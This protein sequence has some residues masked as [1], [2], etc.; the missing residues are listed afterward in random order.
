MF[1]I[2]LKFDRKKNKQEQCQFPSNKAN[3]TQ[4]SKQTRIN[5]QNSEHPFIVPGTIC[6][7][8]QTQISKFSFAWK[9]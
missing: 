9:I 6:Y 8:T 1:Q 3:V 4:H 2:K 5:L 7:Q